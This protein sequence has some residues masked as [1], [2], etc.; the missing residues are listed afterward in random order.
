MAKVSKYKV[1]NKGLPRKRNHELVAEIMLDYAS[2]VLGS[3]HAFT[4][5]IYKKLAGICEGS[6][7]A[8]KALEYHRCASACDK[9]NAFYIESP[10]DE[11]YTQMGMSMKSFVSMVKDMFGKESFEYA[12][13]LNEEGLCLLRANDPKAA[14][15][16]LL[17]AIDIFDQNHPDERTVKGTRDSIYIWLSTL[18]NNVALAYS[19]L[20]DRC[21]SNARTNFCSA[22]KFYFKSLDLIKEF[23]DENHPRTF[24]II[25]DIAVLYERWGKIRSAEKLLQQQIEFI[26]SKR[27]VSRKCRQYRSVLRDHATL[28]YNLGRLHHEYDN[29]YFLAIQEYKRSKHIYKSG[30][31]QYE[32]D[33]FFLWRVDNQIALCLMELGEYEQAAVVYEDIIQSM[34]MVNGAF[35]SDLAHKILRNNSIN[36]AHKKA[37]GHM[38]KIRYENRNDV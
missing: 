4:G 19:Q 9:V 28:Q 21:F 16:A 11:N 7:D 30:M 31:G 36:Q 15:E 24:K 5:R 8:R 22:E 33:P 1:L 26:S 34:K 3:N 37:Y 12:I 32:I 10:L 18:Y 25:N 14:T 20:P 38:Y 35:E 17:K 27:V 13:S 2:N 23:V 6:G 29:K